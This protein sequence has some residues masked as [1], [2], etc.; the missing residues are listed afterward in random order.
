MT[1]QKVLNF[2][3]GPA[4]IPE[5][6]LKK[7]QD[8]LLNYNNTGMSIMELSHR[9]KDFENLINKTQK[10][11][12]TLLDIPNN[13]TILFMQG[14]GHT[15][16]SAVV[17]NLLAAKKR[18]QFDNNSMEGEFNPPLD[19][20]VTG[21]WSA[22]AAAEAKKLY[23][24]VNIVLDVKKLRGSYGSIPPREEWKLSG[25]NAA[26]VYYCDNETVNGVEFNYVPEIDPSVP[27]VC[28]MSSNILSRKV[29]ISKFSL[30]Y[31]GAQKNIGPAG[32]TIVIV[33]E[34]L[35][36]RL[37]ISDSKLPA[38]P[39]MLDYKV[40]AENNSLYNTPPMFSIYVAS[41][42]FEWLLENGGIKEIEKI[43]SIK[44]AKLYDCI[45]KS[46][47]YKSPVEENVRS[48]MNVPF[49][50]QPEELENEFLKGANELGM[51]QLKGHRSV[52]GIR[53][54]I[55]NAVPLEAVETLIQY[56]QEFER[57]HSQ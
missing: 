15:Q 16:F 23:N 5:P 48:R 43:N 39:S 20:I 7:A 49:R 13:Y 30:I 18:K 37:E 14:G 21:S 42:V 38:I 26:Y 2:G 55:Y 35:L 50:I 36:N 22:K 6:V 51:L 32:V 31:A 34:D 12:R 46:K 17:Y 3:P 57:K 11:L 19:Y 45:N 1:T 4:K 54:S 33:R 56:M 29:D 40:M 9:S 28:D 8:E 52:G 25:S 24:N 53:A 44:A 41:L 10:D 47:I 27:L